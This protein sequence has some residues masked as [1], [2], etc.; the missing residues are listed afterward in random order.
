MPT[1]PRCDQNELRVRCW[2]CLA[3]ELVNPLS[4]YYGNAAKPMPKMPVAT[5]PRLFHFL[6]L[7]TKYAFFDS[8]HS[9]SLTR[10]WRLPAP[11]W[12]CCI[13]EGNLCLANFSAQQAKIAQ[14][15]YAKGLSEGRGPERRQC[16]VYHFEGTNFC[17]V[18]RIR[19]ILLACR[20]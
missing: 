13:K 19:K 12:P 14:Q 4:K 17:H 9:R 10:F 7:P 18:S 2:S 8:N 3:A 5:L 11:H 20:L 15:R 6:D 16:A 1:S